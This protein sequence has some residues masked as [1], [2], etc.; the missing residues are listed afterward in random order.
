MAL[1]E[2]ESKTLLV[3]TVL[4]L[5]RVCLVA[6]QY[7]HLLIYLSSLQVWTSLFAAVRVWA[8]LSQK[9]WS[10]IDF[11]FV[12]AFV[13]SSSGEEHQ[14]DLILVG[15][16]TRPVQKVWYVSELLYV[17]CVGL[18][19]ISTSLFLGGLSRAKSQN[20]TG[21]TFAGL[22]AAWTIACVFAIA[23]PVDIARP[24][25]TPEPLFTRWIAVE[26]PGLAIEL[27]LWS[28][29]LI[30]IWGLNMRVPRRLK[31]ISIFGIRLA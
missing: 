15:H 29:A 17:L 5:V 8:K 3:V 4:L 20:I 31:L 9:K 30:L 18:T 28:F 2:T 26:T 14:P 27:G 16:S 13:C 21:W 11:I 22:S 25:E 7:G 12:A 1:P 23:I 6:Y 19:R 10:W 24:W